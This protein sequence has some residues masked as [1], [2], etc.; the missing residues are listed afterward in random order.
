MHYNATGKGRAG[1]VLL[2]WD[3]I[4]A[5]SWDDVVSPTGVLPRAAGLFLCSLDKCW[6]TWTAQSSE[7]SRTGSSLDEES[8]NTNRQLTLLLIGETG[9][10]ETLEHALQW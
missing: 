4:I 3:C 1:W 10:L 6:R 8:H 5:S 2:R 7:V 9:Y